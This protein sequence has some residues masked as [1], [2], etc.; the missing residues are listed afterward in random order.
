MSRSERDM[1]DNEFIRTLLGASSGHHHIRKFGY[2]ADVDSGTAEDIWDQGGTYTFLSSAATL[3][4]S[5]S[6]GSD[7]FEITVIGLDANWDL[8]TKTVTLTGQTQVALAG[9]WIRVHR[10]YNSSGTA[11]VGDI[12]I[13]ETDNLTAGVPDTASKIK[14]K[15]V[16]G[17]EQTLMAI[18]TIPASRTGVIMHYSG[19]ASGL[20]SGWLTG[21]E[22]L[23]LALMI[24]E[25]GGVFR[26]QERVGLINK[27]TTD[28][29][30]AFTFGVVCPA[31]TDIK[32]KVIE[33]TANN[34]S[35]SG[36]FCVLMFE[37]TETMSM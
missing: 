6:S 4:A 1:I 35:V 11:A 5:S 8:Q 10:V 33:T 34:A 7:T 19:T 2:N 32:I 13:A 15:I 22:G 17:N 23:D 9:T 36:N 28:F 37:S 27:G 24:R 29:R 18:Y 12:Y 3:Y 26:I 25:S 30:H 16:I 20:G 21:S 31:K 14:A